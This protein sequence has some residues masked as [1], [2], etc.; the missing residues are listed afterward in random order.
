MKNIEKVS[1]IV[2]YKM[3]KRWGADALEARRKFAGLL[4]EIFKRRLYERRGYE[5]IYHFAAKLAGMSHDQVNTVLRLEKRFKNKPALREALT[6]GKISVNKLARVASI[7]SVENQELLAD[8]IETLS[9]K[10]VD[11]FVQDYKNENGLSKP[12]FAQKS[13]RAQT[14]LLDEDIETKLLELQQKGID[15]NTFLRKA[16]EKREHEIEIEKEKLAAVQKKEQREKA[17]IGVPA[18][19]Y[20]PAKILKIVHEEFGTT[21]SAPGCSKP[22]VHLH[23]QNGFAKTQN[24]DPRFLKPL[25]KAHHEL[26]HV[27]DR[28]VQQYRLAFL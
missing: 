23:H 4:P 24:H 7:A 16:L 2:L 20:V 25:C 14:L 19:R 15:I 17:I 21:C 5:S 3:C 6:E 11:V 13:L 26:A 10:A 9:Q 12:V 27:G 1:D 22:S 28:R 8:K 18:S